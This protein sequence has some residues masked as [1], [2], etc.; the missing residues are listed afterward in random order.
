MDDDAAGAWMRAIA[1]RF[2]DDF[3]EL[4]DMGREIAALRIEVINSG[5]IGDTVSGTMS[6]FANDVLAYHPDLIIWQLGTNDVAWGGGTRGLKDMI[7]SGVRTLRTSGAD[8]VLMEYAIC[9]HGACLLR[10]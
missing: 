9:A 2:A 1:C 4:N 5:R 10:A 3:P 8:I 6:R 7:T